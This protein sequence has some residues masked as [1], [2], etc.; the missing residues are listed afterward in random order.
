MS[1]ANGSHPAVWFG[2]KHPAEGRAC[3]ECGAK[4]GK[5]CVALVA[6]PGTCVSAGLALTGMHYARVAEV[7]A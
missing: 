7:P 3:P 2:S 5:P 1:H 4:I 6:M